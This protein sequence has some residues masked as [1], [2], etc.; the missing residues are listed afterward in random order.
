MTGAQKVASDMVPATKLLYG[1]AEAVRN[2]NEGV[3]AADAI[4][5]PGR[6]RVARGEGNNDSIEA[7]KVRC[8]RELIDLCDFRLFNVIALRN[9]AQRVT[10]L[11]SVIA[12]VAALVDRDLSD[13]LLEELLCARW[14]VEIVVLIGRRCVAQQ[15]RIQ[16]GDFLNRRADKVGDQRETDTVVG[17]HGVIDNRW[18][19]CE[20]VEA[21]LLG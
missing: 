1:H 3:S 18:I 13:A 16:C 17:L 12:P 2:G 21:I 6:W 7:A 19:R 11:D 10:W 15:A 20:I 8:G 4:Q 14:K 5:G 9:F